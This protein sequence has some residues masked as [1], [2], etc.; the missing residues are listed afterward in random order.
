VLVELT[1]KEL[2]ALFELDRLPMLIGRASHAGV[3]LADE[4][5]SG[6]HAE[7]SL[8]ADALR[9][10][11][12]GSHN[13]TF[14]NERAA[15][16]PTVLHDG[17]YLRLGA[18]VL[19]FT[20]MYPLEK[21]A[22]RSLVELTLRDPLTRLYNRRYFDDRLRSEVSFAR[23][24]GSLLSLLMVDI[25]HFKDVNDTFG[26]QVGDRVLELVAAAMQGLVRPE[27]V[28]A[29][30][31]GEEFVVI[32]RD[33]PLR[34]AEILAERIRRHIEELSA[35]QP[36]GELRVTVSV[37]VTCLDP[38]M[39]CSPA[40]LVSAADEALYRAKGAGRNRA[41]SEVPHQPPSVSYDKP[42]TCRPPA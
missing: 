16:G 4:T 42:S 29:R 35:E 19:K 1:G 22:L 32:A 20:W 14:V 30:Y 11:D 41:A 28:L 31:G 34:S 5:V 12:L 37:G 3:W 2:G 38:R 33:T 18:T 17:D 8:E 24:Q 36:G 39:P 10:N 7:L 13:G 25:D 23:R 9:V 27:D 40:E 15:P 6:E 26:H 21:Q